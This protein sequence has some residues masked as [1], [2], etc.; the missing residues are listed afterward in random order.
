M[1]VICY[2]GSWSV[3]RPG[4]GK[5]EVEEI[6]PF[7]CSHIVYGFTGLG[8]DNRIRPLDPY[9]DLKDNWGKGAIE[10]FTGLKQTNKKLKTLVAI[11]GWNEG[12][13]KYSNMASNSESRA[14]FVKSVLE[15]LDRYGFDGLDMDWGKFSLS[16]SFLDFATRAALLISVSISISV[17]YPASRGGK[18]EDK[19]NF[20]TL[21]RELKQA[22]TPKGYLLTAAVSAGKYFADPAYDIPQVSKYLDW[23]GVM[24][25]DFH[26]GWEAKTGHNAPLYAR[27]DEY[28]TDRIL[29]VVRNLPFCG[30]LP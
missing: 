16:S 22:F 20:V 26:G 28:G 4:K 8:S 5:F 3:Y 27:P 23:I 29:N 21:L 15:F 17:E 9:N 18:P 19:R 14:I 13:I 11:G 6:D 25:Y 12:S 7:L 30:H 10:R 2:Y 1:K 24:A